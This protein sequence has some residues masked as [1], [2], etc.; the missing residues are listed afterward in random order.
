MSDVLTVPNVL[1]MLRIALVPAV[2]VMLA[3]GE[4]GTALTLCFIA[5]VTDAFDG[6]I[7]RRFN[8]QSRL[9]SFLDPAADKFLVLSSVIVLAA[10]GRLPWWLAVTLVTRDVVIVSGAIAFWLRTGR[11]EMEPSLPSKI[12]TAVQIVLIL[13]V[14]AH[15]AG[16]AGLR[17][18]LPPLMAVSFLAAVV[19]GVHYVVVW[20]RKAASMS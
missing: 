4:F 9:G 8:Q 12:S 20:A 7:A 13:V 5:G 19:S 3:R 11:L 1:S 6:F 18:A 15:G 14:I 10:V 2:V 17:R 16:V